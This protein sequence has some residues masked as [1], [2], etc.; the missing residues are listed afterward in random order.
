MLNKQIIGPYFSEDET[1]NQQNYLHM[2]N[3]Y[4][5]PIIQRKRRNNK[6]ILQ[7][8]GSLSHFSKEVRTWLNEK[9][10]GRWIGRG[11]PISWALCS[12]DLTSLDFFFGGGGIH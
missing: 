5:Y 2:L 7:Q 4:F 1:V 3:N 6:M 9:S 12:P 8:D 10:N 11:S